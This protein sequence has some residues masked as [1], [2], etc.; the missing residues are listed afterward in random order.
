[1]SWPLSSQSSLHL[2]SDFLEDLNSDLGIYKEPPPKDVISPSYGQRYIPKLLRILSSEESSV[3]K[4]LKTLALFLTSIADDRLK[5]ECI[6][7][8]DGKSTDK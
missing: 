1:M 7:C 8:P 5:A 3:E 4:K 2:T 6:S